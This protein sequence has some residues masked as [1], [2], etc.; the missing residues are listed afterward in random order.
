MIQEQLDRYTIAWFKLA[1]FVAR[2]EKERAL[3]IYKLLTHS[4][5]DEAVIYQ[6][7]GDLL[8]AFSDTKAFD[9]YDKAALIYKKQGKYIQAK[10]LYEHL[11]ILNPLHPEYFQKIFAISS[12]TEDKT[13]IDQALYRWSESIATFIMHYNEKS[14]P[15]ETIDIVEEYHYKLYENVI[16]LLITAKCSSVKGYIEQ[17]LTHLDKPYTT[18]FLTKIKQLDETLHNYA[19]V[20]C[21]AHCTTSHST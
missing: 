16:T 8:L 19:Q 6:L 10:A 17:I 20:Y 3:G 18:L 1:E 9:A 2:K 15:L 12:I 11:S 14:Y 21:V 7:E 13:K 5:Q 4:I